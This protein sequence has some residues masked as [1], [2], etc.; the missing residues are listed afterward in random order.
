MKKGFTLVELSIV[1]VIIG[2]LISGLLVGQ[3]MI[4]A[5]KIQSQIKQFQQF[6]VAVA[7]FHTMYD[8]LPGDSTYFGGDGDGIIE[9]AANN[10]DTWSGEI[11]SF[12][13]DLS[14][15]GLKN[16][17][18]GTYTATFSASA[19]PFGGDNSPKALVGENSGVLAY[20]GS[21][22]NLMGPS[23]PSVN[24]Y[25]VANFTAST[26][27]T[28][29]DA[30]MNIPHN[31]IL[32]VDVKMDDGVGNSGNVVSSVEENENL[33]EL[34]NNDSEAYN[35]GVYPNMMMIVRMGA[36]NGEPR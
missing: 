8:S 14:T 6:D 4:T 12:W 22:Q 33:E 24:Q 1:L 5:S 27:S 11:G 10:Y 13:A 36:S 31:E 25:V 9:P 2:L 26:A 15:I 17:S 21:S 29:L 32:A 23:P 7:N 3:S 20:G 34:I 30:V 28:N 18:G 35:S 16:E 19:F